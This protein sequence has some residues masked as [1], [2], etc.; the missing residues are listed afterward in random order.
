MALAREPERFVPAEGC[1]FYVEIRFF[2]PVFKHPERIDRGIRPGKVAA[3]VCIR[4]DDDIRDRELLCSLFNLKG[5]LLNNTV[6]VVLVDRFDS[7]EDRKGLLL[8]VLEHKALLCHPG[9]L[10]CFVFNK[11]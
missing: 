5:G 10:F 6:E 9:L 8:R 1:T 11:I 3:Q 2:H 7:T 4:I